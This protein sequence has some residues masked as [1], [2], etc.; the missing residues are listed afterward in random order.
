MTSNDA[1]SKTLKDKIDFP[2]KSFEQISQKCKDESKTRI[3]DALQQCEKKIFGCGKTFWVDYLRKGQTDCEIEFAIDY[4]CRS[5]ATGLL[6][7]YLEAAL[8]SVTGIGKRITDT[9]TDFIK[10]I[11][12]TLPEKTQNYFVDTDIC[13]FKRDRIRTLIDFADKTDGFVDLTEKSQLK[14]VKK[15]CGSV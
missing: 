8:M 6:N 3:S 4:L 12:Y 10:K 1:T 13:D 5:G 9:F 11:F 7:S 15:I 14:I 2:L